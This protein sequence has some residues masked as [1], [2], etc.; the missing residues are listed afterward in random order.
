MFQKIFI[1]YD[2]IFVLTL[3]EIGCV[4]LNII[5]PIV[6]FIV[7]HVPWNLKLILVPRALFPN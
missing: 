3:D 6:I 2:K 5:V 4:D 7:W 1:K